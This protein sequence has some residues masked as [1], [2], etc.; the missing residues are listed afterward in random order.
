[1][2]NEAAVL[3]GQKPTASRFGVLLKPLSRLVNTTPM[4]NIERRETMWGWLFLTPFIVLT[5]LFVVYPIFGSIRIAFYNYT[6]I[7]NPTQYVGFRHFVSVATDP[8]FWNAF[9]NTLTYVLILVPIQL[10]LALILAMILNNQKMRF[11]TLYRTIYFLPVVTSIAIVAVIIR[12][13]LG[14]FGTGI[15]QALGSK[16]PISPIAH[17]QLAM[18]SVI[19][20]GMW[21]SFG[22]NLVYFMAALQTV[23]EELYDAAKVDGADGF[24]RLIHITLPSIRP[25][26]TII[27]F[28]SI[29]G[30]FGVFEQ[31]FV[32]TRGEPYYAS[33][34]VGGYIYR[35]AFGEGTRSAGPGNL[36]YASAASFFMSTILLG[37][38]LLQ[39]GI[40]WRANRNERNKYGSRG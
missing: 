29:I 21:H 30:S 24:R 3:K 38:A 33:E 20:F 26:A 10:S 17:P 1:M 12:L 4:T 39:A 9:R 15:S 31:S 25:V 34:V 23:P 6:G 27:I 28:L 32:L 16:V 13:M 5:A 37:I 36:G 11:R 22:T 7:G 14:Q 18:F 40:A 2:N 8:W 35:Y 19:A